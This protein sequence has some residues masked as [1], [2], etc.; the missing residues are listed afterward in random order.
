MWRVP[1]W[2]RRPFFAFV[3][4]GKWRLSGGGLCCGLL[5]FRGRRRG[6]CIPSG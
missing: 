4:V 6:F 5:L 3:D 2:R 1:S